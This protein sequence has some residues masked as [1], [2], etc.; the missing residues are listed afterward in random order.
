VE[1]NVKRQGVKVRSRQGYFAP[2]KDTPA[3]RH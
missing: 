3:V 1:I 2:F